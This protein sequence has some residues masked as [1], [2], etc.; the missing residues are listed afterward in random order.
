MKPQKSLLL[1]LSLCVVLF[2]ACK[3]NEKIPQN[4]LPGTWELKTAHHRIL[5]G[6]S[7]TTIYDDSDFI[8]TFNKDIYASLIF[9]GAPGFSFK[10]TYEDGILNSIPHEVMG[11]DL[12]A[13]AVTVT[14]SNLVLTKTIHPFSD[15]YQPEEVKLNFIRKFN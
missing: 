4:K 13:Y 3:K 7:V 2:S 15:P 14:D 8:V 1:I 11:L 12:D 10:Y 9:E 6:G 5:S